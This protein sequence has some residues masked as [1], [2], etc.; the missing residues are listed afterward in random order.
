[1]NFSRHDGK[2]PC[3]ASHVVICVAAVA[4]AATLLFGLGRPS[5]CRSAAPE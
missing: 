3:A 4:A 5:L 1:M 2:M